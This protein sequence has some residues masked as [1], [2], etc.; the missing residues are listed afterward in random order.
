MTRVAYH[1]NS[2]IVYRQTTSRGRVIMAINRLASHFHPG[3]FKYLATWRS[4]IIGRKEMRAEMVQTK[5]R[6]LGTDLGQMMMIETELESYLLVTQ[7]VYWSGSL[8]LMYRSR[9]IMQRLRMEAV[10]HITSLLQ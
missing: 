4:S 1:H 2:R 5:R 7:L 8:I 6:R 10:E 9:A 3:L